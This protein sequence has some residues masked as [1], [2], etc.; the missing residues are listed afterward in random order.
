MVAASSVTMSPELMVSTALLAALKLPILTV[1][2]L[3]MR[4][5]SA[6]WACAI[7][8]QARSVAAN[9]RPE[10]LDMKIP[11]RTG[12]HPLGAYSL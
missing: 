4:V 9:A 12:L 5:N 2:G 10:N 3:G 7:V 8:A 11:H 6:A 1:R